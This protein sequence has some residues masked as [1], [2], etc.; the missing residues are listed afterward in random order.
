MTQVVLEPRL[1]NAESSA[2]SHHASHTE[3]E[4]HTQGYKLTLAMAGYMPNHVPL[5]LWVKLLFLDR[6]HPQSDNFVIGVK[7]KTTD[8][9]KLNNS[10]GTN[11]YTYVGI[12]S[13]VP[14]YSGEKEHGFAFKLKVHY[15]RFQQKNYVI[16]C[17]WLRAQS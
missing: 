6:F 9:L 4:L 16:C 15:K 3:V 7:N 10:P 5:M 12:C 17:L 2:L 13:V 1:F 8:D 11:L 14:Q